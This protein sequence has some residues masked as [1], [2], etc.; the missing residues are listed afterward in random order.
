MNS[1]AGLT[2]IYNPCSKKFV[3]FA[4]YLD[5]HTDL[6]TWIYYWLQHCKFPQ[7]G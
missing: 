6:T 5:A 1:L 3:K 7:P 4:L 2:S